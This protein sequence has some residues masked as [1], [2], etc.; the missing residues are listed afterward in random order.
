MN[1][2]IE[3]PEKM[4]PVKGNKLFSSRQMAEMQQIGIRE[5]TEQLKTATSE[6]KIKML[7]NRIREIKLW[8]AMHPDVKQ[9]M[10]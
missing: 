1:S 3:Y 9:F 6:R 10:K 2:Q 7:K 4:Y 5:L 8:V